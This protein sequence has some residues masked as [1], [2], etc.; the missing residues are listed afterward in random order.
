MLCAGRAGGVGA[1]QLRCMRLSPDGRLLAAGDLAGNVHVFSTA[2][3]R[4]LLVQE[5]H[6][7]EVLCLDFSDPPL[8]G[9]GASTSM[10]RGLAVSGGR[11]GLLHVYAA[12]DGFR[13]L[14][15][16]DEHQAAVTAA[17]FTAGGDGLVSCSAD[18]GIVFRCVVP[19]WW[20]RRASGSCSPL[21][22]GA[23]H[24]ASHDVLCCVRVAGCHAMQGAE[25]QQQ[26]RWQPRRPRVRRGV[27]AAPAAR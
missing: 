14:L 23:R 6:D 19:R 16:L 17:R 24:T 12:R 7:G 27:H 2:D 5:A 21:L 13:L 8:P 15:S 25:C 11:D 20:R 18:N 4:L 1:G 22:P 10:G 3:T 26:R 9:S